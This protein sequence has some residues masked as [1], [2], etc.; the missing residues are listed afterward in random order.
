[1]KRYLWLPPGT[2]VALLVL[3]LSTCGS[4][5][6]NSNSGTVSGGSVTIST[7]RASYT[8]TDTIKV[9]VTNHLQTSI[10]AY[11]TR[12]GCTI[13]GLQMQLN[14]A[15]NDTQVARCPLGRPAMRVEIPA[16]KVY[17]ASIGAGYGGVYS[18]SFPVGSYRLV[19]TYSTS[20]TLGPQQVNATTTTIYSAT[21][22]VA[23]ST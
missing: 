13:L 5:G 10:F 3:A 18:A 22:V 15:W 12:A 14:S 8:P 20:A 21:I 1:M 17:T 9:S 7:D 23:N 19:L 16:G 6:T 4:G 11:D 2:I